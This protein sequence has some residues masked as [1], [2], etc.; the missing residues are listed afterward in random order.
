M[1]R[2]QRI[3]FRLAAVA[4]IVFCFSVSEIKAQTQTPIIRLPPSRLLRFL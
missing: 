2:V 1:N 4:A 3:A